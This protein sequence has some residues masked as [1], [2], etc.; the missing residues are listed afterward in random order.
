MFE[1]FSKDLFDDTE[2]EARR[3]EGLH[4]SIPSAKLLFIEPRI[5]DSIRDYVMGQQSQLRGS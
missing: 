4:L 2:A 1:F 3:Y 5:K